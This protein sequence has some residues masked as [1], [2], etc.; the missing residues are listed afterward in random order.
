MEIMWVWETV[1]LGDLQGREKRMKEGSWIK[2]TS[3]HQQR[4]SLTVWCYDSGPCLISSLTLAKG[5]NALTPPTCPCRWEQRLCL[6]V[7]WALWKEFMYLYMSPAT[8]NRRA[9]MSFFSL[10][11]L[12]LAYSRKKSACE[13]IPYL[14]IAAQMP[15]SA[16][17]FVPL[18]HAVTN[19][20]SKG[21]LRFCDFLWFP[22]FFRANSG[23]NGSDWKC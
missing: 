7:C 20:H 2:K 9:H 22:L 13:I 8:R 6:R 18:A 4:C 15:S 3:L 23:G 11:F 21:L 14:G 19:I 10:F 1:F 16:G 12:M 17:S 5:F